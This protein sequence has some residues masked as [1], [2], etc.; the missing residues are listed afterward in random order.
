MKGEGRKKMA[1]WG[2]LTAIFDQRY[3]AASDA[4]SEFPFP[5]E[6]LFL[7]VQARG[8]RRF[9]FR[10][11]PIID[12]ILIQLI[13]PTTRIIMQN[14]QGEVVDMYIPRKCSASNRIIHAKDHASVQLALADVDSS[15]GRITGTNKMYAICGDI[16]R[17]GE[18][19][20]CINRLAKRDGILP[21]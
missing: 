11:P 18:S 10:L 3:A 20:D 13:V 4:I 2:H 12:W 5:V 6:R 14:D 21:K 17:M 1:R 7:L 16:R 19:D 15:T 8:V 9:S